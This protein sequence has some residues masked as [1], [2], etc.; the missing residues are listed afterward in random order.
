M[1]NDG[2][3]IIITLSNK[4]KEILKE[5]GEPV[6]GNQSLTETQK[7]FLKKEGNPIIETLSDKQKELLKEKGEP[8]NQNQIT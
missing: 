5:K 4:Q 1:K 2:I 3:P 7:E 6:N 8:V